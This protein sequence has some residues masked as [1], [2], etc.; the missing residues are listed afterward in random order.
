L[1]ARPHRGTGRRSAW[2]RPHG[3]RRPHRPGG[4][5]GGGRARAPRAPGDRRLDGAVRGPARPRRARRLPGRGPRPPSG[6]R[7]RRTAVVGAVARRPGGRLAA[8]AWLRGPAPVAGG[9]GGCVMRR[10]LVL[11]ASLI[12]APA[13]GP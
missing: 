7:G 12:A 8:V 11:L 2:T 10:L 13:A 6:G 3:G 5:R 1:R 9:V 4:L